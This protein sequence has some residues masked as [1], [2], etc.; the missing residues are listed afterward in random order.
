M[1]N[2][3]VKIFNGELSAE[4][5]LTGA[6]LISVKDLSYHE[7]MWEADSAV[8][9]KCSPVLFPICGGL[10]DDK[11]ELDGHEYTMEKHGFIKHADFSVESRSDDSVTLITRDT[12]KTYIHYP[13]KFKFTAK[14]TLCGNSLE[15]TYSVLNESGKTMYFSLGAHEA[16]ACPEGIEAYRIEFE[17]PET[18]NAYITDGN[19][20]ENKYIT[21][22]NNS[23]KLDLIYEYFA[24]DALVFKN[25]NSESVALVKKDGSVKIN[26]KFP[27]FDYFLLWTKPNGKY[28][29]IEPWIGISDFK[30]SSF[31]FKKKE[32]ITSLE[33]NGE[34]SVT[35]IITY[36]IKR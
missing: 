35:H 3:S 11:Y 21:I 29:C 10:K 32:G 8:W 27:E 13:F 26:V 30:N 25:L 16:Y 31:D 15:V 20:L 12:E 28:I 34:F 6:E 1:M 36:E 9:G 4:I 14:F 5:S 17:K 19:I 7:F 23:D 2:E 22:K 33:A 18:L 24:V